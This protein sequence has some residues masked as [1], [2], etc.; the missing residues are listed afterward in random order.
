[1]KISGTTVT[2]P[3]EK[4]NIM[5]N[6]VSTSNEIN[7]LNT[8]APGTIK[9]GKAVIYGANGEVSATSSGLSAALNVGGTSTLGEI[10]I[11]NNEITTGNV[12]GVSLGNNNLTTTGTVNANTIQAST[13][14]AGRKCND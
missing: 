6:V 5:E 4:L 14:N 11:S 3:A 2:A 9:N 7:L 8:S 12:S 1:M 13:M 10:L